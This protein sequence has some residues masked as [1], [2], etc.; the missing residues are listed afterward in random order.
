MWGTR[1]QGVCKRLHSTRWVSALNLKGHRCTTGRDSG[2][3]GTPGRENSTGKATDRENRR[4]APLHCRALVV[5]LIARLPNANATWAG[6]G[7]AGPPPSA[8]TPRAQASMSQGPSPLSLL[9]WGC[10]ESYQSLSSSN[11]CFQS[12][13]QVTGTLLG[14]GTWPVTKQ[15]FLQSSGSLC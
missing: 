9:S 6:Y 3:P 1:G 11:Q 15:A 5:T 7:L 13:Y 8:G 12:T 14:L 4:N 10:S 2:Q